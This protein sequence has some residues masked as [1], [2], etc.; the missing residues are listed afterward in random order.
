MVMLALAGLGAAAL[1]GR[2]RACSCSLTGLGW[3]SPAQGANDVPIDVVPILRG[4]FAEVEFESADGA[5]VA[6]TRTDAAD[7]ATTCVFTAELVPEH[8]L[9]ATT[10]YVIRLQQRWWPGE[11][12][13]LHF[14][15]GKAASVKRELPAP[16][17]ELSLIRTAR[18]ANTC[19]H[20]ARGCVRT[21]AQEQVELAFFKGDELLARRIMADG[22]AT[23]E[24]GRVPDCIEARIRD[25]AGRR[26]A[27]TR[28]CGEQL[29]FRLVSPDPAEFYAP[30]E[31]GVIALPEG[32]EQDPQDAGEPDAAAQSD[33]PGD[34]PADSAY[35]CSASAVGGGALTD[36]IWFAGLALPLIV[37][38]RAQR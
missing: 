15:T 31:N 12:T 4:N 7:S 24:L 34:A 26:S 14:T 30:C 13:E 22:E 23:P 33:P 29:A 1:S 28:L 35:G 8:P 32:A 38:R 27:P 17:L 25:V 18:P 21:T 2:A 36:A 16:E 9:Q 20:I 37:R 19:Q 3:S 10:A 6:F 11:V 5:V